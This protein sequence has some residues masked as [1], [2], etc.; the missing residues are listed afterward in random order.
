M[1]E[2]VW[3]ARQPLSL[4]EGERLMAPTLL[5]PATKT[6][7]RKTARFRRG[8]LVLLKQSCPRQALVRIEV[9]NEFMQMSRA[10]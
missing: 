5:P 8:I 1:D 2:F 9:R 3:H 6:G 4:G 7:P 10:C